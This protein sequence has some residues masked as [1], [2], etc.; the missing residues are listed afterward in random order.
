VLEVDEDVEDDV[1]EADDG[2]VD[3]EG[4]DDEPSDDVLVE[5]VP[6]AALFD[7]RES[8]R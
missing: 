3:D 8:L 6:E 5:P 4:V 7:D 2:A 1:V